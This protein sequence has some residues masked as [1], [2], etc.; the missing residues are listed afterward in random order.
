MN[1]RALSLT[2]VSLLPLL[3]GSVARAA[4]P[5]EIA[6]SDRSLWPRKLATSRDFDFASRAENLVF[7][8]VLGD[9]EARSEEWPTLL[10]VKQV[11][12][13]STRRWLGE[14]KETVAR[15]LRAGRTGC[16]SPT[17]MGCGGEEPTA[18]NVAK[19]GDTFVATLGPEYREWLAMD[20]RFHG[21]YVKEL[22]RLA[23]LFPATT[24][25]ILTH[26]P[27]EETGADWPDRQFLLTFDDG[28]TPA[29]KGT[30]RLVTL[31]NAHEARGLFF[32]VGDALAARLNRTSAESLQAL[33]RGQCV[34]SH[35]QTHTSHQKSPTWKASVEGTRERIATL[36]LTGGPRVLFRPPYGQ[37]SPELTQWLAREG[38][39]VLLWNIDSQD[40]NA[41]LSPAASTD[42]VLTLM[43]LWRHG[44]ILFHDVHD[45]VHT[46][47]P[48]L[49]DFARDTGLTWKDCRTL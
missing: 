44:V 5:K 46:A 18:A 26:G 19:L 16:G 35:G 48:R 14:V 33:Y 13:G 36:G 1:L 32:V 40:W 4:G 39:E 12:A 34:G 27:G 8:H 9:L 24:S 43:L 10:G 23:A 15:N 42:R 37:R 30:D 22:L 2:L 25:E 29:G 21:L 7:A 41:A 47:V 45:K 31:L 17:D 11:N 49:L 28:P 38:G 6:L 3:S 20:S